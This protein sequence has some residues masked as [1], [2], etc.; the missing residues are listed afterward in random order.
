MLPFGLKGKIISSMIAIGAVPLSLGM[1]FAYQQ[2]TD[3]LETVIGA[4]FEALSTETAGKIDMVVNEEIARHS[5]FVSNS[6]L[7]S[8]VRDKL[9]MQNRRY[10]IRDDKSV[11][12]LLETLDHQW[13]SGDGEIVHAIT[14][15]QVSNLLRQFISSNADMSWWEHASVRT[16]SAVGG[17]GGTHAL[18]ITDA[19]GALLASINRHPRYSNASAKWWKDSFDGGRGRVHLGDVSLDPVLNEYVILLSTPIMDLTETNVLGIVHRVYDANDYFEPHI[20]PTRFGKS[21]HVMLIDSEGV[22]ISCPILPTGASVDDRA[23]V[24]ASTVPRA[25]WIKAG[26]DGHGGDETSI[27]G[28]APLNGVNRMTRVLGTRQWHTMTWQSSDELFAPMNHLLT[29]TASAGVFAM[30]LLGGLGYYAASRIVTP[31]RRLQDSAVR[32]AQGELHEPIVI[33][34]G[35]EIEQLAN[36]FNSM[37]DQLQKAFSGLEQKVDEK[38]REVMHL[39]EYNEKILMS[40]P[41]LIVIMTEDGAVEYVNLAFENMMSLKNEEIVGNNFFDLLPSNKDGIEHVRAEIR[42]LSIGWEDENDENDEN[43]EQLVDAPPLDTDHSLSLVGDPL[44]PSKEDPQPDRHGGELTI[45]NRVVQCECFR[46]TM[47][48]EGTERVGLAMRDITEQRQLQEELIRAEKL[49]GLGTLTAGIAHELNNPLFGIMGLAEIIRDN[50]DLRNDKKHAADIVSHSRH[51]SSIIK[52]FAGYVRKGE[53]DKLVPVDIN[54][55]LDDS[56]K[57]AEMSMVSNDIQLERYYGSI[58]PVMAKPDEIQQVFVNVIKNGLQAMHGK[59]RMRLSSTL[60]NGEVKVVIHDSG[61]G[62]PREYASRL[63]DPFFTTKSQGEGTGLGLTIVY[64]IVKKY[65][66]DVNFDTGKGDGTR[67]LISFPAEVAAVSTVE[68]GYTWR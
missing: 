63:F 28:F 66:G 17:G 62:I 30:V 67:F 21:G 54:K 10:L 9:A 34:T 64:K 47:P 23:L 33:K 36:D 32:I 51:M 6:L 35:D 31:I 22:V 38:T 55:K 27:L 2:G 29:W 46:V 65:G 49:A 1:Y 58:P 8:L 19:R 3:Q 20:N 24:R 25:G 5:Q 37:N 59:G 7:I 60:E 43:D 42:R 39:K 56:F 41:D 48:G 15:G 44:D 18:F 40:V 14:S 50:D 53:A 52:N 16:G 26:S 57:M 4:S 45:A 68:G 13:E 11:K 12:H 61:S